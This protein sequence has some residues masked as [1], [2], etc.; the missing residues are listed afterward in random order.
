M[1]NGIDPDVGA[2]DSVLCTAPSRLVGLGFEAVI[3][4]CIAARPV[5]AL[6]EPKVRDRPANAEGLSRIEE[7]CNQLDSVVTP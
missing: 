1:L 2:T 7:P 4:G 5:S 6:W 3:P